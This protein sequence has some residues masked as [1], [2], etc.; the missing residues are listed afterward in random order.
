[1]EKDGVE[2]LMH[3]QII[4]FTPTGE[5][6][7]EAKVRYKVG[8]SIVESEGT[9]DVVLLA[10]GR[11]PNVENMG[12][13]K[14]RVNYDDNGIIV[15]NNLRTSNNRVFSCGDCIQGPKFTHNSDVQARMILRNAFFFGKG[16]KDKIILPYCT[17][18]DPEVASVGMNE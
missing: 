3:T 7:D 12:L 14:A 13:E 5:N 2:I 10:T 1:M 4:Q 18:T 9:F 6:G 16:R 11:Q 8:R 15:N 17:Y